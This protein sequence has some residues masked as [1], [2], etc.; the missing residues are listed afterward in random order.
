MPSIINATTTTGLISS[1]DTSGSL[2]LATNNGTAAVTIDTSQNVGIG[3][4]SPFGTTSNR[5]VLS[6]NGT[7]DSMFNL[8]V[9]GTRT[10]NFYTSSTQT[11]L[12][13]HTGIPLVFETNNTERAR[14]TSGGYFKASSDGI[15]TSPAG[16]HEVCQSADG[17]GFSIQS[18]SG[19]LST[20][21][22]AYIETA[23]NTTNNTYYALSYY[24]TGAGV[25]R[26][27]VADSGAIA[28]AGSI[29]LGSISPPT[30]GIGIS[31]PATQS[32]S[33]DANTLDDYEEGTWTPAVWG[34]GNISSAAGRYIKIGKQ[35]YVSWDVQYGSTGNGDAAGFQNLPFTVFNA[36]SAQ[37]CTTI[38][39]N[40]Y[41]S[42]F[43]GLVIANSTRVVY[44]NLS[45]TTLQ[46]AN[47]SLKRVMGGAVYE[48]A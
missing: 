42:G 34:G 18:K 30:S 38:S 40:D 23:R 17:P 19:S 24:N 32:A 45:G 27:R 2:Q 16:F 47:F 46:N 33:S 5:T 3:T 48:V 20:Y 10:A 8:G 26:L 31:F 15:Y 9:N 43:V 22:V 35:V 37:G 44:Y 36:N 39:Y 14:I 6:V 41:G 13:S 12:G 25:Y 29:A 1:G 28:T 7:T 21:G 4:T 11:I